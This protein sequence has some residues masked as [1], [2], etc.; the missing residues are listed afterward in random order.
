MRLVTRGDLDGLV[1]SVLLTSMEEIGRIE[2]VHPQHITDDLFRVEAGDILA[3]LPYHPRCAM[4]FSHREISETNRRP[5]GYFRGRHAIAPSCSRVILDHY[6]SDALARFEPLVAGADRI[7]TA[8]LSPADVEAPEGVVLLGLIVDPRTSFGAF[9]VFFKSLVD[10]L[11]RMS[12]EQVLAE[13]DVAERVRTYRE[14]QEA[15]TRVLREHSRVEGGAVVTDFRSC[16]TVPIGNRFLVYSLYPECNV[17]VRLQWGPKKSFVAATVGKSI[18]NRT[19]EADVGEICAD[20][21]GGGH[22]A[23][24]SAPLEPSQADEQVAEMIRLLAS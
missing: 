7:E 22:H 14:E 9:K 20:M 16:E 13:E 1:S 4:W 19:C 21:G 15:F 8:A 12:V 18:F 10:R 2:L 23:A 3:K 11:K 24:G 6:A 5:E 17:S